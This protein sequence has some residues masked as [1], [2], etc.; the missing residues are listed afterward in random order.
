MSPRLIAYH[1]LAD[2]FQRRKSMDDAFA[3][4]SDFVDL[5]GRDKGFVRL[6]VTTVLKRQRQ[7]DQMI[8]SYLHDPIA[9]LKP[10]QLLNV[11]R[12]GFAQIYFFE[13]PP[14]AAVSTTVDLA[15]ELGIAAQKALV[16]AVMRRAAEN[17]Q[18]LADDLDAGRV[19][20]PEWLFDIWANDYGADIAAQIAAANLTE[21]PV[22]FTVKSDPEKWATL[23]DAQLM[24]GGSLRKPT[25][26][27]VPGLPGFE[28]G[29]WW[30]QNI[31]ASL[32]TKVMG[33]LSGKKV[34]DLCAAPGG[35]TAQLAAAGADVIALD[36]SAGRIARLQENMDRL[37]LTVE[38]VVA[39]GSVWQPEEKVDAVLLDAPCSATG[40]IRHQPDVLHL[41]QEN[42]QKKLAALQR[43]L[44]VNAVEMLKPGGVLVYC[45]CSIQKEEGEDQRSWI[46]SQN[47][48]IKGM[49][50]GADELPGLSEIITPEGEV[51]ALPY[52][53]KLFNGIDGFYVARFARL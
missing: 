20:T 4:A 14:H 30:I 21:A 3:H 27:F 22:D 17:R 46:L 44:L 1:I 36:R 8:A 23:L 6:L 11:F 15:A 32:P 45:T 39:D 25:A 47:Q 7:L 29:D 16:N 26:G 10:Q 48:P 40:T 35:K 9:K 34:V 2:I 19:N 53:L 51:R 5:D 37:Q 18:V 28:T 41:K 38:T 12:I 52:H 42:D 31:A 24:P 49:P 33:D 13:T 50:I 43:R